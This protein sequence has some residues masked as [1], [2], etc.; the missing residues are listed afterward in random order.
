MHVDYN[1]KKDWRI[2]PSRI[3]YLE[4]TCVNK[5]KMMAFHVA[6]TNRDKAIEVEISI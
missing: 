5:D 2:T 6:G 3:I 4:Q 1:K